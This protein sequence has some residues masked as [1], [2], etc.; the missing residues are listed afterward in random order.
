MLALADSGTLASLGN[1][2]ASSL[3]TALGAAAPNIACI[4]S[5]VSTNSGCV[6]VSV[7]VGSVVDVATGVTISAGP[8]H[9]RLLGGVIG[10]AGAT[11]AY[12]AM[13]SGIV[14]AQVGTLSALAASVVTQPSL[15]AAIAAGISA[16]PQ[17]RLSLGSSVAVVPLAA[18]ADS[19]APASSAAPLSAGGIVGI[20]LVFVVGAAAYRAYTKPASGAVRRNSGRFNPVLLIREVTSAAPRQVSSGSRGSTLVRGDHEEQ[21]ASIWGDDTWPADCI[22]CLEPLRPNERLRVCSLGSHCYCFGCASALLRSQVNAGGGAICGADPSTERHSL[23][24]DAFAVL[25]RVRVASDGVA[26]VEKV[27]LKRFMTI[28][29]LSLHDDAPLWEL[30]PCPI[31]GCSALVQVPQHI[32]ER[33]GVVICHACTHRVCLRCS[34]AWS[35]PLR[36]GLAL[37]HA[38]RSCDDAQRLMRETPDLTPEDM[39]RLGIKLCPGC[40]VPTHRYIACMHIVCT[41]CR[42]E[43]NWCCGRVHPNHPPYS[44]PNGFPVPPH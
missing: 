16:D 17:L 24:L 18:A 42:C 26:G 38:G 23:F 8:A 41:Q 10:S 20:V 14:S 44:C 37:T 39:A 2:I 28:L 4:G 19:T 29:Q 36:P 33:G 9:G 12:A 27:T 6:S 43:W 31:S 1:V 3:A 40:R 7:S 32:H 15:G 35:A 34:V 22:G 25:P 30:R 5:G 13:I 11:V 21:A